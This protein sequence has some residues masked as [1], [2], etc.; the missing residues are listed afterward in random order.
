M[1]V[2]Y[3]GKCLIIEISEKKI[4]VA[5]DLHLGFEE[6][7]NKTGVFIGRKMYE[8][9]VRDFEEILERSGKVSEIILLGDFKHGFGRNSEQ[10]WNEGRKLIEYLSKKC[11]KIIIIKGNH[12]NY[13]QN[14]VGRKEIEV[15]DYYILEEYAFLH[16]D[17]DFEEIKDKK[18]KVWIIGHAHPAIKIG[19][20]IRKE[21][22]KCFLTGK[23]GDKEIIIVPSFFGMREGSDLREYESNLAWKFNL[24]KF[25]VKAVGEKLEIFDFGK[26]DKLK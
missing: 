19:N 1:K 26:L 4:L 13:L 22:Y 6:A 10:E 23:Y 21:T 12:D 9:M 24:N 16:G 5:G 18:I 14:L 2:E 7:M 25:K 20:E 17:R 11:N 3:T 8:E 15:L